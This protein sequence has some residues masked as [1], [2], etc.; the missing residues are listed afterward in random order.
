MLPSGNLPITSTDRQGKI[1]LYSLT[2]SAFVRLV[3]FAT[4]RKSRASRRLETTWSPQVCAVPVSKTHFIMTKIVNKILLRVFKLLL[5]LTNFHCASKYKQREMIDDISSQIASLAKD[6]GHASKHSCSSRSDDN[7][8]I[9]AC[10]ID[11][12]IKSQFPNEICFDI[13]KSTFIH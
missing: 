4:W 5:V 13:T 1:R 2:S 11:S 8:Q 10:V 3:C 6:C 7:L 9:E 12:Q